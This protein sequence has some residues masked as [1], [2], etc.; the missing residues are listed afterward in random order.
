MAAPKTARTRC[1]RAK[2]SRIGA[3]ARLTMRVQLLWL[4]L[5]PRGYIASFHVLHNSRAAMSVQRHGLRSRQRAPYPPKN[6]SGILNSGEAQGP[7]IYPL[8]IL[9]F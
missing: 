6:L 3:A 8:L 7:Q 9:K 5:R 1:G 4:P 2:V